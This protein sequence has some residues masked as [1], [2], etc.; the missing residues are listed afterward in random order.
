MD[1]DQISAR[2]RL[3]SKSFIVVFSLTMNLPSTRE[4]KSTHIL[5]TRDVM[6]YYCFV[7]DMRDS[8]VPRIFK[9]LNVTNQNYP[10]TK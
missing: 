8:S 9:H 7:R 4:L 2:L 10:A 3:F 5:I 6:K 1:S